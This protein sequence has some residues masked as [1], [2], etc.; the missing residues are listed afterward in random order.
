[1][2]T[3]I[4]Q[5]KLVRFSEE[6]QVRKAV[7]DAVKVAIEWGE[8]RPY[9]ECSFHGLLHRLGHGDGRTNSGLLLHRLPAERSPVPGP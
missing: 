5:S 2:S 6:R 7:A 8:Q 1:M 3:C 4:P 9:G